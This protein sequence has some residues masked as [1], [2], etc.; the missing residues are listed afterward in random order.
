MAQVILTADDYGANDFIDKGIERGIQEGIINSVA[1]FV[2]H[3]DSRQRI[4]KL[5]A[6]QTAEAQKGNHFAIGLHFSVTSGSPVSGKRSTLTYP[7]TNDVTFR[8][9][10][11]YPFRK[12]FED[13]LAEELQLQIDTLAGWLGGVHKID[14]VSNHHG[15]TYVEDDLFEPYADVIR[16]NDIPM[17]SPLNWSKSKLKYM[18]F[19]PLVPLFPLARV[20]VKL[21]W[22]EKIFEAGL[23]KRITRR[24]GYARDI[25]VQFPYCVADTFYGQPFIENIDYL[26]AQ[27]SGQEDTVEMMFHLGHYLKSP[28]DFVPEEQEETDGVDNAYYPN[29]KRELNA[30]R[31]YNWAECFEELDIKKVTYRGMNAPPV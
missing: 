22:I 3:K 17:R 18:D 12:I 25:G 7:E 30:I 2:T 1:A 26:V 23:L 21:R 15:V 24:E 14:H 28:R 5:A 27:L 29:R 10:Y 19:D 11:N 16:K 13:D 20:G 31:K 8:D 9:A 6:L 4:D